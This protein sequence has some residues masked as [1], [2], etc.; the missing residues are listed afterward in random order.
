MKHVFYVH[1]H[2]TFLV[3]NSIIVQEQLPDKAVVVLV[4]RKYSPY[5]ST[6]V[7]KI[8]N[9]NEAQNSVNS[10]STAAAPFYWLRNWANLRSIDCML[11]EATLG[12]SFTAYLPSNRNYL[13]QYIGSHPKCC[14]VRLLEE[15]TMSYRSDIF[16]PTNQYYSSLI[17]K[18]K[19]WGKA[20]D[21]GFRSNFYE[22][23]KNK[24]GEVVYGFHKALAESLEGSFL[25][26]KLLPLTHNAI[27]PSQNLNLAPGSHFFF[28]DALVELGLTSLEELTAVL[29]TFFKSF[30]DHPNFYLKFHPAQK[31]SE[32]ILK[33]FKENG[34]K[35][36]V[37][38]AQLP[39]ELILAQSKDLNVFG[40]YSSLLLYA[41]FFGHKVQTLY[42]IL[43][44]TSEKAANWRKT[45]MPT[46]F[47][48]YVNKFNKMAAA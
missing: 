24:Q 23:P 7:L 32:E 6:R 33:I 34:V 25:Q 8:V 15:G 10:V 45:A 47:E 11:D 36:Q 16:K 26:V 41:V 4:G 30:R 35:V 3:T 22:I 40:F 5:Q 27:E 38:P 1:S 18:W 2:I 29:G 19:K 48:K 12:Q 20:L 28:M 13:M 14:E 31:V 44:T 43:E 9:L 21:H 46:V 37:L 17:G 39:A 42:P